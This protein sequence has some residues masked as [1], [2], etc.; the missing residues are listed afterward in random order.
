MAVI[1]RVPVEE[2][3]ATFGL[4]YEDVSFL[5]R[6]D[7]IELKGWFFP[8]VGSAKVIVMVHGVDVHRADPSIGM[9]N[10]AA[11][12]VS[13]GFNVLTFDLR[14][15]GQS[16][17]SSRYVGLAEKRDLHGA[18]DFVKGRGYTRIGVLGFSMGAATSLMTAAE[19]DDIVAIVADSSFADMNDI[20]VPQF[21]KRTGLPKFLLRP[22]LLLARVCYG[23]N[24][25]AVKP[26]ESVSVLGDVPILF[27]HG[28]SDE[29][30]PVEHAHRL[31]NA[32]VNG[33]S[34]IWI[35]PGVAHV[36]SYAMY[37]QQYLD[38]VTQFFAEALA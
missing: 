22:L 11:A 2:D 27:I 6:D 28:D 35:T 17:G 20:V 12:L 10:I 38:R 19:S 5:S 15:H 29:T 24:I 8:F 30:V 13:R 32:S 31:Y 9:L 14:G 23:L 3:P 33:K 26:I 18:V 1:K 4:S 25:M 37:N 16:G 7:N 34:Q 36:R 21:K